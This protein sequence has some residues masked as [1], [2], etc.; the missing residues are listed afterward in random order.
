MKTQLCG[1]EHIVLVVAK[2]LLKSSDKTEEM[3]TENDCQA[4]HW[5]HKTILWYGTKIF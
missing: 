3:Q 2:I 4:N 5:A 1:R